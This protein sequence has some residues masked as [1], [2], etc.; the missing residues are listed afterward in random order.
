MTN[1]SSSEELL[2][3]DSSASI[4]DRNLRT[5]AIDMYKIYQG[6][7]P[8]IM[9]EVFT[10]RHQNQY[11]FR[12]W[13]YFGV[14]K[15]RTVN[16]GS[17]SVRY[18]GPKIWEIIPKQIHEL[19]TIDKFKVAIKK[20][21]T[22]ILSTWAMQSLSTKYRLHIDLKINLFLCLHIFYKIVD[23]GFLQTCEIEIFCD[24]S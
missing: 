9:N 6:I 20:M 10:L 23:A 7:S 15:V 5:L 22:R 17:E 4:Q 1:K 12:N 13:T 11:N 8:N 16:N 21:E 14:P 24:C 19:D 2:E 18:L 3:T